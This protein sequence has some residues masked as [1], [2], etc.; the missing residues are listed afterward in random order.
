[1]GW[2]RQWK[3]SGICSTLR[4]R[5]GVEKQLPFEKAA[6]KDSS[7]EISEQC[8]VSDFQFKKVSHYKIYPV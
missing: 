8:T 1:M 5:L 7:R 6:G 2:K 3:T 4:G